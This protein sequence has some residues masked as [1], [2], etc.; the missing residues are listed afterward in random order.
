MHYGLNKGVVWPA[1]LESKMWRGMGENTHWSD[2]SY[3]LFFPN[4]STC[5]WSVVTM[6]VTLCICIIY[7]LQKNVREWC[8]V[9]FW[10]SGSVAAVEG[11]ILFATGV[12][13]EAQEEDIRD[14]FGEYGEI[15]NLHLN[16]DRRTGF[17]KVTRPRRH[18]GHGTLRFLLL[19]WGFFVLVFLLQVWVKL[20]I[21]L[22]QTVL[23][24]LLQL[25]LVFNPE[26]RLKLHWS[27]N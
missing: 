5:V 27:K 2:K 14:A 4:I 11:W 7:S 19:G 8:G 16:L 12:H 22:L 25:F 15:K 17:L 20:N 21:G 1:V 9:C 10:L 18:A 26:P 3:F 6:S 23:A 13:E 24:A